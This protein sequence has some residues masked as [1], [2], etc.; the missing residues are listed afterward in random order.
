MLPTNSAMGLTP[1]EK[2]SKTPGL[3]IY[4]SKATVNQG[5][6]DGAMNMEQFFHGAPK[7]FP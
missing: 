1:G 5:M 4:R 6:A 7:Y 2:I 3:N